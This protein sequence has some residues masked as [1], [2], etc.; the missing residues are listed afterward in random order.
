MNRAVVLAHLDTA[1]FYVARGEQYIARLREII[2]T[3]A[4]SGSDASEAEGL[5]RQVVDVQG[6]YVS[7]RDWLLT[8]L[9]DSTGMNHPAKAG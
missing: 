8:E 6:R 1:E 2:D 9:K 7:H 5:L 4:Q 3:L